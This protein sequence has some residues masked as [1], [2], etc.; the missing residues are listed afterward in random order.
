MDTRKKI[1][2]AGI[3]VV[4]GLILWGGYAIRAK[5][6]V[7]TKTTVAT[8][9]A[10][11]TDLP[12][13]EYGFVGKSSSTPV[14]SGTKLPKAPSLTRP[15]T[16]PSYF[17]AVIAASSTEKIRSIITAI[18]TEP[19]NAALWAQL[20]SYRKGIE[21]Y[22]GAKEALEYSLA[23]SPKNAV[24]TENLGVIYGDYLHDVGNA[25]KYYLK[26]IALEPDVSYRYLRLFELYINNRQDAKA[27]AIL[28]QGLKANPNDPSLTATL[29]AFK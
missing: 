20:G 21:D 6:N 2:N 4:I 27:K 1:I 7:I 5:Q 25:E 28:E 11:S 15:I 23:L 8:S 12:G 10:V 19:G 13:I 17:L 14:V 3:V 24:T 9:T 26:A 29:S 18:K 22:V 16:P